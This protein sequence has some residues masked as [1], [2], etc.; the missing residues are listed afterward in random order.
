MEDIVD[1]GIKS[2]IQYDDESSLSS[3]NSS[4]EY[5][6]LEHQPTPPQI[7]SQV[8]QE[9]SVEEDPLANKP[10][11]SSDDIEATANQ[12]LEQLERDKKSL[13]QHPLFPLI[14]EL[15]SP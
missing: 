15:T 11:M 12:D 2:R 7:D 3:N 14:G 8:I 10:I 6:K 9:D 1:R 4:N 5:D 13:Y